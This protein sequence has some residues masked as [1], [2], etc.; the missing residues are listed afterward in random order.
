MKCSRSVLG[1]LALTLAGLLRVQLATAAPL[2]NAWQ[3][4]DN[5]GA[6]GSTNYYAT[7]LPAA[8]QVAATNSTGGW[9]YAVTGRFLTNFNDTVTMLMAY[10]LGNKRFL[11]WFD[12]NGSGD[13]TANLDQA[14][15]Y[16]L[17]TNG[18]GSALYHTHEIIYNPT[19]GTARYLFDGQ[20]IS[21][22]W[23]A[24]SFTLAAGEVRWGASAQSGQ[25][26]MNFNLVTFEVT[27]TVV[28]GYDAGTAGNPPEAPNPT[29]RGWARFPA[30]PPANTAVTN[31]SPDT[32]LLP[33][34]T[35][36]AADPLTN[37][38]ARLN[39]LA[40]P[41]GSPAMAWFEWD[42]NTNYGNVT[43]VQSVGKGVT[44]SN[45]TATL[46][47]LVGGLPHHYRLVV[48]NGFG[49]VEG[50]NQS[51]T[52]AG[53]VRSDIPGLPAVADGSVAW[54]DYNNDG[55]QDFLL[56]GSQHG[57]FNVSR[58][59][60]NTGSGFTNVTTSVAPGLPAVGAGSVAWG[61]YDND[62][63]L[64]FLLTGFS[65]FGTAFSQVWR[66]TGGGFTNAPVPGL[67]AV[68]NSSVAWGDYDNDG[69]LDFLLTGLSSTGAV[70]QL[71]R[72]TGNGF[73]A[74]P[75]P[76]LTG[77]SDSSVAWG[78]YDNDGWLDFLLTG[79]DGSNARIQLWR[80][81]GSGFS[82]L[83][84]TLKLGSPV[85]HSSVA[86]GDYDNDGRLDFLLTG[87]SSTG[88]V[89]QLWRNTGSFFT[90]VTPSVAPGLPPVEDSSVAWGDYDNDGRLDFLLTGTTNASLSGAI[91]Q[92]WR[93]TPSGFSNVTAS[94][95]PG[96]PA[97]NESAVAWGDHDNDG[98]LDL[99]LTGSSQS[100]VWRNNLPISNAPPSAPTALS[101]TI[102]SDGVTF[103]WNAPTDDLTPPTGLNYNV[104]I[105]STPGASDVLA[106]MALSN[107]LRLLPALGNAQSGTNAVLRLPQGPTYWT[108]QAVDT[109]FAGSPFA[110]EQQLLIVPELIDPVR[111]PSGQFEFYFTNQTTWNF[112]VLVSTNAALPVTNW[113]NLGMALNLGGGL[114]R[115]TDFGAIGQAQRYYMLRAQ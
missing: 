22:N 95:V 100:Q 103:K 49:V 47:E 40:N 24:S 91:S 41:R 64:D 35:T 74:V 18:A 69:L 61:D 66:N 114:Y 39:G 32:A 85:D 2:P 58:L 17:T 80:N 108:V 87:R 30:S 26:K 31:I 79:N 89:S 33:L 4:T 72:N 23:P 12:L 36:L 86:W 104:R 34:A 50:T 8:L 28:A 3:I 56:T 81:T 106:P 102:T 15:T 99:L 90:N 37:T 1:M 10:G 110:T 21:N 97:L 115:F 20:V 94:V 111:F 14:G 73:G 101:A 27:N 19:N 13:L 43:A 62:G 93:N 107:G 11:V 63:Q 51:F 75:V 57:G 92:L 6:T 83:P 48:S 71:W 96:L 76:G 98:R 113:M 9:R 78:D 77:V 46:G 29:N 70:S 55:W 67:T 112:D 42:T 7:N 65:Q 82:N 53:F 59:M 109:S 5:S 16:I 45:I 54:G 84:P 44:F 25:G 38:S 105:G 68:H 60:R 52:L 88:P